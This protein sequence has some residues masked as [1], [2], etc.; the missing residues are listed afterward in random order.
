MFNGRRRG[1]AP[2]LEMHVEEYLAKT[3]IQEEIE[4]PAP[5]TTKA[6][7]GKAATQ[8]AC[9]IAEEVVLDETKKALLKK[10]QEC[11]RFIRLSEL[12]KITG[13]GRSTIYGRQNRKSKQFDATFPQ[14]VS[15][16][17]GASAYRKD[18]VEKWMES[19]KRVNKDQ[20]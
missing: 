3:P 11:N 19:R 10:V 8:A 14:R 5:S 13:L 15:I 6:P 20:E 7:A 9:K 16:G 12:I 1:C 2:S 17:P 4:E 18:E